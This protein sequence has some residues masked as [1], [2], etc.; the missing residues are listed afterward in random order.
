MNASALPSLKHESI[1][2]KA[3]ASCQAMS[4]LIGKIFLL[5]VTGLAVPLLHV[6]VFQEDHACNKSQRRGGQF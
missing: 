2:I 3:V 6:E 1:L 4:T 5:F